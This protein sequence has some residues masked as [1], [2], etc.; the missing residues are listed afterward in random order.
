MTLKESIC[1]YFLEIEGTVFVWVS[2]HAFKENYDKT[3]ECPI[4]AKLSTK[5]I[6]APVDIQW[7]MKNHEHN[8]TRDVM[9]NREASVKMAMHLS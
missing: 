3:S 7:M 4:N 9:H 1:S 2:L 6:K 5:D 8:V